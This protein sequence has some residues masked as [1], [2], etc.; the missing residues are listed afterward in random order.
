LVLINI[1]GFEHDRL[2]LVLDIAFTL[3]SFNLSFDL[4][5]VL[6]IDVLNIVARGLAPDL[7]GF[8]LLNRIM[9]T[10]F[11]HLFISPNLVYPPVDI[12]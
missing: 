1:F 8:N 3:P 4:F 2:I 12:I 9:G 5:K 7:L 10:F 11:I 6:L